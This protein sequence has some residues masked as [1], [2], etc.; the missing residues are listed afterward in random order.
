M[1][2]PDNQEITH[3]LND[4]KSGDQQAMDRLMGVVYDQLKVMAHRYTIKENADNTL[5]TP[6]LVHEAYLKILGQNTD[7]QNRSHFY[8]IVATCMRRVILEVVRARKAQKR[9]DG[10]HKVE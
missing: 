6:G 2:Q 9:G 3:L 4:W 7:L 1:N 8:A 5:N 10:A